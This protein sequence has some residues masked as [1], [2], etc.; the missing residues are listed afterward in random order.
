MSTTRG[1]GSLPHSGA[2]TDHEKTNPSELAKGYDKI[3]IT[4]HSQETD[5]LGKAEYFVRKTEK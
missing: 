1:N 5:E 4:L 3:S 2:K